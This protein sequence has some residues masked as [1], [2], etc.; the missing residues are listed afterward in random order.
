MSK[1]FILIPFIVAPL[2]AQNAIMQIDSLLIQGNINKSGQSVEMN[3][4]ILETIRIEAIIEKPNVALIPKKVETD[5]GEL[6]F[7]RRSFDEEL[8]ASPEEFINYGKELESGKRISTLKKT[9]AK[10][11]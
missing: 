1:L 10:D 3:E 6:P 9:L 7:N 5:V 8:K 11:N 4:F 2:F